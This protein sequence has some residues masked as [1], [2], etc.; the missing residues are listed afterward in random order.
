MSLARPTE[1]LSPEQDKRLNPSQVPGL[2]IYFFVYCFHCIHIFV[3]C[4][5]TI[6]PHSAA[7]LI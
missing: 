7:W 1:T 4:V 3:C 2:L 6:G 5:Y